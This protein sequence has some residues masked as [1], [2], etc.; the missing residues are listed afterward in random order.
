MGLP[1]VATDIRGC[2]QVV[3]DGVCGRLVPVRDVGRLA[4]AVGDLV[5]DQECRARMGDRARAKA[6]VEFDQ[7]RIINLTLDLYSRL[8]AGHS[9]VR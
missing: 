8:L 3:D 5:G 4:D 9:L 6:R 7:R 1:I 2:R